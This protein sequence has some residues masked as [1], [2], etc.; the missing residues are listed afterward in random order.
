MRKTPLTEV[1][2]GLAA[3]GGLLVLLVGVPAALWSLAGWPLPSRFPSLGDLR[4]SLVEQPLSDIAILK[5]VATLCWVAWIQVLLGAVV[6][7]V[8]FL[9]GRPARRVAFR[10]IQRLVGELVVSVLVTVGSLRGAPLAAAEARP[11][12]AVM[13]TIVPI[14]QTVSPHAWTEAMQHPQAHVETPTLDQAGPSV[15]QKLYVVRDGQGR[16]SDCL[17]TIAEEHLGDGYR[18]VEIYQLNAGVLQH[19]GTALTDPDRISPG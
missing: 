12:M 18:W 17:W 11:A 5:I 15:A 7:A 9:R 1:L 6:E 16:Y 13:S 3:L 4:R 10:P 19:D 14:T 8:S 2:R